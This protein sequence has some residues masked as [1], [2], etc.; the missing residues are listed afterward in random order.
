MTNWGN[1]SPR[2][3]KYAKFKF[4]NENIRSKKDSGQIERNKPKYFII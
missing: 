4:C 1:T 2:N 3:L